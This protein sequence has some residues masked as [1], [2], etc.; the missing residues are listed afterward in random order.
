MVFSSIIYSCAG[1]LNCLASSMKF[2]IACSLK[3]VKRYWLVNLLTC[4]SL[5]FSYAFKVVLLVS[6]LVAKDWLLLF[7][8]C[9]LAIAKL[10]CSLYGKGLINFFGNSDEGNLN[11][12][13]EVDKANKL[14]DNLLY[15]FSHSL[16]F[17]CIKNLA[18]LLIYCFSISNEA[19]SLDFEML[20]KNPSTYSS[21]SKLC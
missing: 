14:D 15:W 18:L 8:I 11:E 12:T 16:N 20:S 1:K 10:I 5:P 13:G 3:S 19:G 9:A 17:S 21:F 7:P 2:K 4:V 6:N